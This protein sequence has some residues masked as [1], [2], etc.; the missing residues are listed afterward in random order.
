M[1]IT[2]ETATRRLESERHQDHVDAEE[3]AIV[4]SAVTRKAESRLVDAESDHKVDLR[5]L[6]LR[7]DAEDVGLGR[8]Q[9]QT[10]LELEE[11][12]LGADH[13]ALLEA[14]QQT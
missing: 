12:P 11:V 4:R 10:A 6:V 9:N 5:K 3:H 14:L 8:K 2:D 13:G 1:Q 7:Y